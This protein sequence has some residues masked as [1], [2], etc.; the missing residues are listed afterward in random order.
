[1]QR[2]CAKCKDP[3]AG[4][5]FWTFEQVNN[6]LY[7]AHLKIPSQGAY[8]GAITAP[9]LMT[10]SLQHPS[11]LLHCRL[12]HM[13][14]AYIRTLITNKVIEGLLENPPLGKS[15]TMPLVKV[16]VDLV[17]PLPPSLKGER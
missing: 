11:M 6:G 5:V 4:T 2:A 10:H 15:A 14:E 13:N 8:A 1:M 17:G 3:K 12:G 16:H 7:E 9:S